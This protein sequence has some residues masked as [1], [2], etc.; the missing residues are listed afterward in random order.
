VSSSG[1]I[2]L[3][4]QVMTCNSSSDFVTYAIVLFT[5]ANI[6]CL[7]GIVLQLN[8][9]RDHPSSIAVGVIVTFSSSLM[10]HGLHCSSG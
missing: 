4:N 6:L 1:A 2:T 7:F 9:T 3:Q 5:L 8:Q 10:S